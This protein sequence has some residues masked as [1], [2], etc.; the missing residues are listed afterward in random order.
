M[1][2]AAVPVLAACGGGEPTTAPPDEPD[3]SDESDGGSE[4]SAE[5]TPAEETPA[6]ETPSGD[7]PTAALARTAE[8]PVG[9]GMIVTGQ[10]IVV[11]QPEAGTFRAFSSTC[12]HM[13]CQVN[14]VAGGTINCPCHGSKFSVADGSVQA[15]PAKSPLPERAVK[16]EGDS[17]VL[18]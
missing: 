10:K 18:A 15:G 6:E 7:V 11:T 17:I 16:V 4:G 5:E 3:L 1:V 12:T 13:G 9:G 2:G 14:T 8:V